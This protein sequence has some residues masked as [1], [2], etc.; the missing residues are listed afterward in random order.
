LIGE[1]FRKMS[2]VAPWP[3]S[4]LGLQTSSRAAGMFKQLFPHPKESAGGGKWGALK[5]GQLATMAS[6]LFPEVDYYITANAIQL[7]AELRAHLVR[8]P[9]RASSVWR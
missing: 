4:R 5:P 7:M 6:T 8:F 3:V 1:Y 9:R 2:M